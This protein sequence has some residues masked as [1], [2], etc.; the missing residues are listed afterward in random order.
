MRKTFSLL[1]LLIFTVAYSN[2]KNDSTKAKL[3]FTGN[4]SLNSNGMATIPAFSLGKPAIMA[5][6]TLAMKRF[7]YDPTVAYGLNM[8]PWIIDNWVHYRLIYKPRFELR[9][10]VDFSMFFSEYDTGEDK[11]L[12]GQQYITFEIAGIYKISPESSFS[13]MYWS[14][15]GQDPGSM[16]GNFYNVVY[17]RTNIGIGKS[18]LFSV[19]VQFFYLDYTGEN[20]GLFVSPRIASSL[21]DLPLSVFFQVTQAITSNVEPFPGF[22]W[23]AGVAYLF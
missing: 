6:L 16:T 1:L 4:V 7:S 17:D 10:G 2:E 14:D 9:T 12:Q 11:I 5:N 22:R 20:D 21:K 8:R 3:H 19:N 18:F 23:N 15:N 13:L